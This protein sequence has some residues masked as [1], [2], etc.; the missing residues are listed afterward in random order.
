MQIG[1]TLFLVIDALDSFVD[2]DG[3]ICQR[4]VL[5]LQ[6]AKFTDPHPGKQCNEDAEE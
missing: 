6:A 3:F 1:F 2:A 5:H 4:D